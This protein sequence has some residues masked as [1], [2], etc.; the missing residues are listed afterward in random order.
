MDIKIEPFQLLSNK[1]EIVR[2]FPETTLNTAEAIHVFGSNWSIAQAVVFSAFGFDENLVMDLGYRVQQKD[3]DATR[4][5]LKLNYASPFP[6]GEISLFWDTVEEEITLGNT[7]L[8]EGRLFRRVIGT[9]GLETLLARQPGQ[10]SGG[11]TAKVVL[12]GHLLNQPDIMVI[13]RVLGE[14]DVQTRAAVINFIKEDTSGTLLVALDNAP[15]D[16]VDSYLDTDQDLIRVTDATPIAVKSSHSLF[17]YS[18]FEI[19]FN[20]TAQAPSRSYLLIDNLVVERN[21]RALFKQLSVKAPSGSLLWVLGP[22]GSGKTSFF[23]SLLNLIRPRT[24][25]AFWVEGNFSSDLAKHTAYSPQDPEADVIELTIVEE[26]GL[27]YGNGAKADVTNWLTDLGVPS[28]F[29][30]VPLSEDVSLKKLTSVLAAI[31]RGKKVCLL[32][33]PT[34]FLSDVQ[35]SWAIN[36]MRMFLKSGGVILCSTHDN[37]LF[38]AFNSA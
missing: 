10:L 11:E 38:D 6:R 16:G 30:D 15:L 12:A 26:V 17:S 37:I 29:F 3:R 4:E 33:E 27:A 13:D 2:S 18:Q 5:P 31:R 1:G 19:A 35:K 32:D 21:G 34:L 9:L 8:S 14:I 36:A 28:H 20:T 24:G 22:N 25:Q 7:K 23:E